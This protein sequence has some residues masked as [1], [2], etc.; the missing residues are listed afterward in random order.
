MIEG[1]ITDKIY[2]GCATRYKNYERKLINFEKG[3]KCLM[4]KS[5]PFWSEDIPL[6]CTMQTRSSTKKRQLIKGPIKIVKQKFTNNCNLQ[7]I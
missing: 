5:C 7:I 4:P 1:L 2:S 3:E 6:N